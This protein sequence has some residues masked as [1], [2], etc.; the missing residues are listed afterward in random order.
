MEEKIDSRGQDQGESG[1]DGVPGRTRGKPGED[2]R[3]QS[4]ERR[5]QQQYPEGGARATRQG[6]IRSTFATR[7]SS[8]G[9]DQSKPKMNI[10]TASSRERKRAHK[11]RVSGV[12]AIAKS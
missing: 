3:A 5:Q 11:Q 6:S 1:Q 12:Y 10:P 2:Q 8:A 7:G 9:L 4:R